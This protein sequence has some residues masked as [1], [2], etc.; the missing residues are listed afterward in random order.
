MKQSRHPRIKNAI[1]PQAIT[2]IA[3]KELDD[4][5]Y[6]AATY[7]VDGQTFCSGVIAY[8]ISGY[9]IKQADGNMGDLAQATAMYGYY[10]ERYFD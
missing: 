9:C 1:P 5:V 8:S 10:A 7:T 3:A 2:G 6:V 4:T